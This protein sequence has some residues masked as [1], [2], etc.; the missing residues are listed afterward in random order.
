MAF[1]VQI[2]PI[3]T[4]VMPLLA[5]AP[6]MRAPPST[7]SVGVRSTI[8]RPARR[9]SDGGRLLIAKA[10]V[11]SEG[12]PVQKDA[13]LPIK[14]VP[15][16][17]REGNGVGVLATAAVVEG[18]QLVGKVGWTLGHSP[19]EYPAFQGGWWQQAQTVFRVLQRSNRGCLA[20]RSWR[21]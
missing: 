10:E 7:A 5:S 12:Q 6:L 3:I 8:R 11:G 4:A 14:L 16:L 2:K 13:P 19:A 17:L 1:P 18:A 20:C 9:S 21:A 15:A